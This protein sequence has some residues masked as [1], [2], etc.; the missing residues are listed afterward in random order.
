ME[1]NNE[2]KSKESSGFVTVKGG[3][4]HYKIEGA[5]IPCIVI[6][7]SIYHS[8]TFS[9][10]LRDHLKLIFMDDRAYSPS[11]SHVPLEEITMETLLDDINHVRQAL[12]FDKIAVMGHSA[13]ALVALSS[14]S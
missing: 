13:F 7:S 9:R 3:K 10:K 11:T 2:V 1:V 8:R 14:A 12:G 6:G 5:G 4:I